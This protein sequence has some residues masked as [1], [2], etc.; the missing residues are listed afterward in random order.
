M[1][2]TFTAAQH[3]AAALR[4]IG[5]YA[6][7]HAGADADEVE[8]ALLS[9]DKLIA[10]LCGTE[11]IWWLV[12]ADIVVPLTAGVNPTNI[13]T[14]AGL[15]VLAAHE[16]QFVTEAKL[17]NV[18]NGQETPLQ[19]MSR[20][21]F[22]QFDQRTSL[23]VPGAIYIDR[24]LNEPM[25]YLEPVPQE[26]SRSLLL[27]IQR[28]HPDVSKN[29]NQMVLDVAW[30]R[31]CEYALAAD[32]GSGPVISLDKQRIDGY[33]TEAAI[34]KSRLLAFQNRESVRSPFTVFHD[35]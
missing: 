6:P 33:R 32:V 24:L 26:A 22:A 16:L 2:A 28:F 10:E 1:S 11:R 5:T 25:A 23:G 15:S 35:F 21:E 29:K 7:T 14:A 27:T 3:A 9:L 19:R 34:A 17:V 12:P 31:W 4:R 8:V 18:V 20:H 13:V 30:N